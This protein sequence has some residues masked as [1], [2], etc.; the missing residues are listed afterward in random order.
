VLPRLGQGLLDPEEKVREKVFSHL[1]TL[2]ELPPTKYDPCGE[3]KARTLEA[4]KLIP[5]L[6]QAEKTMKWDKKKKLFMPP[7]KKK[8]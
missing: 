5:W 3:E 6:A 4:K 1:K 2:L 7:K 8:A